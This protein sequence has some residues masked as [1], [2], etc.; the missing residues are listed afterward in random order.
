MT[1]KE[2]IEL[3]KKALERIAGLV[4]HPDNESPA[5]LEM[6]GIAR[7]ALEYFGDDYE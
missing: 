2:T 7:A 5:T 1:D 6:R 3:L 4:P